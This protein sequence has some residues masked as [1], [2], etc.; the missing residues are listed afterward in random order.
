MKG[1][2]TVGL[3]AGFLAFAAPRP[4]LAGTHVSVGIGIPGFGAVIT[5]GPAYYPSYGYGYG[6]YGYGYPP[7]VV[8]AAPVY[9]GYYPGPYYGARAYYGYGG[10]GHYGGYSHYGGH[11]GGHGGHYGGHGG[12]YG[13]HGRHNH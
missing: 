12:H 3:L 2:L 11:Y 8:V 1:L 5:T 6:G 7:P 10:Y 13:G 9:Y 4:A